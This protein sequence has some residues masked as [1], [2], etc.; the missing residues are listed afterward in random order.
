MPFVVV[1]VT[2]SYPRFPGDSV[3]TFM[4]PIATSVAAR[5]HEVHVVAPWHPLIDRPAIDRGVHFHFYKYAPVR[6]LNVFGYAAAMHADVKLRGAAYAA[7]PL[8]LAAGWWTARRVALRHRASVMHGH[9]VVPGGVT[10][11]MA[12]PALPLVISLHGSDVFVAER[13]APARIAAR[14]A[15]RRAGFVT[16]CSADLAER[17]VAIGADPSRTGVVPYGVDTGRFRPAPHV[18]SAQREQL[19]AGDDTLLIAAA[20]RLVRK[21]GFEYLVDAL[22]AVPEALLA[23]AGEGSLRGELEQRARDRGVMERVRFLGNRAQD[24]VAALFAAADVIVTPSVRD[25]S[26]NVDGLPNVV[27]EAL[28]SGTALITT[29]AGGIGAVVEDNLTAAIV[30]ER[31]VNALSS[32]LRRLGSDPDMRLRLGSAARDLVE[33]KFGWAQTAAQFEEAYDRALAFSSAAR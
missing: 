22:A 24:D 15:F 28:A 4:E 31:D 19:G 1:M 16:A 30:A 25:D 13:L 11:A 3:G 32:A 17:A 2:S 26:G 10:A 23:I 9:W 21:K 5:G 14:T 27:M 20:G 18:R 29:A 8:A 7:A 33:Q 6:S 12:A